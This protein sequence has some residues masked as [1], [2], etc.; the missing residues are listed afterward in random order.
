MSFYSQE[1]PTQK[2]SEMSQQQQRNAK[3][4]YGSR[5]AYQDRKQAAT[6]GGG[7]D[8]FKP[9]TPNT[10]APGSVKKGIPQFPGNQSPGAYVNPI[11]GRGPGTGSPNTQAPGRV[12]KGIPSE[13]PGNQSPGAYVNPIYDRKPGPTQAP[14]SPDMFKRKNQAIDFM[15]S[16]KGAVKD[17]MKKR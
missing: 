4:R 11:Y 8:V 9:G 5:S 17:K 6:G 1:E 12:K 10:Q 13:F 16:Y 2:W 7:N 14:G 15:Q 3:E